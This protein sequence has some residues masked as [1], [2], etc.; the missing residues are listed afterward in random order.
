[1]RNY[2]VDAVI[3]LDGGFVGSP[4]AEVITNNPYYDIGRMT[5]PLLSVYAEPDQAEEGEGEEGAGEVATPGEVFKYSVRF[6][7]EFPGARRFELTSYGL[8][9][10]MLMPP[11]EGEPPSGANPYETMCVHALNF[12]D[13]YVKGSEEAG[14]RLSGSGL[15]MM[16]AEERPPTQEEYLAILRDGNIEVAIEIYEKFTAIDPDLVLFPEANMNFAG[17]G[18]LQQGRTAEAVSLFKMNAEA[19]PQSSNCWDSL[20]EAYMAN[21]DNDL[22]L[23]CVEKVLETLPNDTN[24]TDDLRQAHETN[25]ERYMEQLKA[26]GSGE[27]ENEGSE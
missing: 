3:A 15:T 9:P 14:V 4:R 20:A 7:A 23:Q 18:M 21:G 6:M 26:E 25:A 17:Y 1:M 8:I 24:L 22:A 16:E 19:Y 12:L 27:S 2:S 10:P 5:A 11:P 13:T